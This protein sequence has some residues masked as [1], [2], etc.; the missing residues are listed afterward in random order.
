[1]TA[2]PVW[3]P[4]GLF[5]VFQAAGGMFWTRAD[6]A[7]KPQLLTQSKFMQLPTSFTPDGKLLVFSELSSAA[8]SE[9]RT[10]PVESGSGQMRAGGPQIF[11]KTSTQNT[12]RGLLSRRTMAGLFQCRSR[13][14]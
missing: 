2:Y 12:F 8:E 9:I 7:G 14:V 11:L 10:V 1:V 4:D 5:I 13:A 3:S 6:G